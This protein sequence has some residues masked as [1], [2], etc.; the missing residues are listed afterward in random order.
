MSPLEVEDLTPSEYLTKA[1]SGNTSTTAAIRVHGDVRISGKVF[2][3]I[4]LPPAQFTGSVCVAD[5]TRLRELNLSVS[6][7]LSISCCP[8]LRKITG[9]ACHM[10]IEGSPLES[11]GADFV[12]WG[13]MRI[14]GGPMTTKMNCHIGGSLS[15]VGPVRA[16]LGPAFACA[17]SPCLLGG[18]RITYKYSR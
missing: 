18:A 17:G 1:S 16:V 5:C 12:C 4:A 9:S 13:S 10:D 6:G 8:S 3:F 11:M 14:K 7:V 15:L 2:D